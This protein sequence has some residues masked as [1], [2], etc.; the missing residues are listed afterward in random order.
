MLLRQY[1]EYSVQFWTPQYK[2]NAEQLGQA[3]WEET[4]PSYLP[5]GKELFAEVGSWKM[6]DNQYE[7][8]QKTAIWFKE[9]V[10]RNHYGK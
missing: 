1:L 8:K 2:V 9:G 10:E 4:K 5:C 6:R 7:L 3:Q